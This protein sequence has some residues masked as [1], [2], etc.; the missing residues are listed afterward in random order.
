MVLDCRIPVLA[1]EDPEFAGKGFTPLAGDAVISGMEE[2]GRSA[3]SG[4]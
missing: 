3:V 4:V 1:Q 2:L